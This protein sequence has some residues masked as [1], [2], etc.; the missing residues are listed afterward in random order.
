MNA[1]TSKERE[2]SME[3]LITEFRAVVDEAQELLRS[4]AGESG[5]KL[6]AVRERIN[7]RFGRVRE[8]LEDAQSAVFDKTTEAARVADDYVHENPWQAIGIAAGAGL[9]VG[10]LIA[11]R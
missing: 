11:R 3:K 1:G 5:E 2:A 6:A 9:I 4:S 10:L 7:E 8:K